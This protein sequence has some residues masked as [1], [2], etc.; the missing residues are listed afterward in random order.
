MIVRPLDLL[1]ISHL[2]RY[3]SNVLSLYSA[4]IL[5]RGN[6]LGAMAM[7][8][9]LD[10][11]RYIYTAIAS[12]AG[13]SLMGQVILNT[14]ET[15]ARLTFMAPLENINGL[16]LALLD[17]LTMQAGTWRAFHLL[18]EVDENSPVFRSLRQSGFS[19]YAWQRIWKLPKKDENSDTGG[20]RPVNEIDWPAVQSL[21]TQ[22]VPPLIQ[23]VDTL[24]KQAS[25]LVCRSK[26]Q[27]QAYVSVYRGPRGVWFQPL[28]PPD[29][30]CSPERLAGLSSRGNRPVYVCVRSYQAWLESAL[31]DL[32][33][34]A[35]MRQAVMVKR[36]AKTI[37]EPQSISVMEKVL[38]KAK[39][40]A[41]VSRVQIHK[42]K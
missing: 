15:S 42:W 26:E 30:E 31:E 32:G 5:T 10:P 3:R 1:D 40:A 13:D 33:A 28:V 16:T 14:N 34:E 12:N 18:A 6:P 29:C 41:P 22:I 24:P 36:L 21:H 7:F 23:P 4:R 39:P 17:H 35:G 11:R 9:Y 25:G 19:V 27:L 8:S 20:W 37:Q 2:A 38:A